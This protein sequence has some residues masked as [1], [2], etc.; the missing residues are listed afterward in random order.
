[1]CCNIAQNN[2]LHRTDF[3]T[4][5]GKFTCGKVEVSQSHVPFYSAMNLILIEIVTLGDLILEVCYN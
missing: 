4:Q 1:M 5:F 2:A 3:F